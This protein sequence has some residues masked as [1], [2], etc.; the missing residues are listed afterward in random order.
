M[1]LPPFSDDAPAPP[2]SDL[3]A[4]CD[5]MIREQEV[6]LHDFG[7]DAPKHKRHSSMS[8]EQHESKLNGFL[9]L[10]R[11]YATALARQKER[12]AAA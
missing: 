4:F 9:W 8:I 2:L 3:V 1:S 10:R 12:K 5:A 6:W 11:G 7:P